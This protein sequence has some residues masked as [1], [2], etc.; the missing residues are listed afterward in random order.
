MSEII[1]GAVLVAIVGF[2]FHLGIRYLQE[3]KASS[4]RVDTQFN[5]QEYV[6][7]NREQVGV[8]NRGTSMDGRKIYSKSPSDL[9]L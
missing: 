6:K 5:K 9:G 8:S 3:I 1:F 7:E 4:Q 2:I